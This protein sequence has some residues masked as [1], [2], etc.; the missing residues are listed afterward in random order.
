MTFLC[1]EPLTLAPI[2]LDAVDV[3][4][5]TDLDRQRLNAYH[6]KVFQ[7]LSPELDA[8]ERDWLLKYTWEI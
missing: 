2:D 3:S 5:L 7:M 8:D 4:L 1:F 6:R